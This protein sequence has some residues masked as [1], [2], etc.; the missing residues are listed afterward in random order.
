M[1]RPTIVLPSR[2]RRQTGISH[3]SQRAREE[4]AG[5]ICIMPWLVGFLVFTAGAMLFS[6]GLTVFKTDL[7][8][9]IKFVGLGHFVDLAVDPFFHKSLIVTSYYTF[10]TVPLGLVV[11]LTI[12]LALNQDIPLRSFWRTLYYLPSV[13]S[14]LAVAI[15]WRWVFNPDIGLLNQTLRLMGIDGPRWL[16][17]EEWAMPAFIIMGLWGSGGGM[18]LY[19]GGLQS[20]PTV[21]YEAAKIDGANRWQSFWK[22]TLPMLS[23]TIFFNLVMSIIGSFQVFTQALVMTNGGPNYATL[24]MVL[25]LYRKGFEQLHFGYASAVAWVLFV[26]ILGFTLLVVRS[27]SA[28]VYYEGEV[29]K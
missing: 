13:V 23:P 11:G 12:A 4:I 5:Y 26:I 27:S 18:L 1:K 16:Y 2:A 21:L 17:S 28:W 20:I 29:R 19:L 15:L 24:T 7:L 22:I 25:Y 8:S 10:V 3:L 9:E 6:L 14:G